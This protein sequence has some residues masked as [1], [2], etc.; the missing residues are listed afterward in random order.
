MFKE[1]PIE[2]EN[3]EGKMVRIGMFDYYSTARDI[4][5]NAPN[6]NGITTEELLKATSLFQKFKSARNNKSDHVWLEEEDYNFLLSRLNAFRWI[7]A[8]DVVAEFISYV[9]KLTPEEVTV[10]PSDKGA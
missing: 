10:S 8:H 7:K 4:I 5:N 6:Q 9:R 2:E 3:P 1:V